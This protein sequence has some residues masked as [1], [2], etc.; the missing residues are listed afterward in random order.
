MKEGFKQKERKNDILKKA[1]RKSLT[2]LKINVFQRW[3]LNSHLQRTKVQFCHS[4]S[5][6][7]NMERC[8]TSSTHSKAPQLI[9]LGQNVYSFD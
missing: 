8:Q 5:F 6:S 9:I 2:T 4:F 3:G 1:K 7:P